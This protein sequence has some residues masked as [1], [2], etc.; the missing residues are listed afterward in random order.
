M[1]KSVGRARI[2]LAAIFGVSFILATAGLLIGNNQW[3]EWHWDKYT[4]NVNTAT[5]DTHW[6]GII[7]SE[8][9]QW[10]TETVIDFTSGSEI[11][12][13]AGFYGINGWLGLAQI[14]AYDSATFS[15]LQAQALMNRSYLDDASYSDTA[16]RSVT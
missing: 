12:G 3:F 13:D 1:T 5:L 15:I 7:S 6:N 10:E 9:T 11:I 2:H 16:D 14:L 8:F 4:I